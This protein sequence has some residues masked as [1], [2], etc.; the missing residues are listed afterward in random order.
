MG[1]IKA[2]IYHPN[3][4]Q[5]DVIDLQKFAEIMNYDVICQFLDDGNKL[6]K[7]RL[8]TL[9]SLNKSDM[10]MVIVKNIYALH[11]DFTHL[12]TI[13][14]S[15][16]KKKIN[17]FSVDD[18]ISTLD[19]SLKKTNEIKVLLKEIE[20]K[21]ITERKILRQKVGKKKADLLRGKHSWDKKE[22]KIGKISVY[23]KGMKLSVQKHRGPKLIYTPMGN[24]R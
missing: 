22:P 19:N 18:G 8:E 11:T 14:N 7:P 12:L 17:I 3:K 23:K 16:C 5:S 20:I 21:A 13:I 9:C 6:I 24:K 4:N 1:Q 2:A 15:F 10:D